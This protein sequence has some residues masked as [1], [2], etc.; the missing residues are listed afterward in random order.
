MKKIEDIIESGTLELYV[1]G[2]LS[3][4][5]AMEVED[6][7]EEYPEVKREV[8]KIEAAL[9]NLSY[10]DSFTIPNSVWEGVL[11]SIQGVRKLNVPK[12]S[13]NWSMMTG[14][15][16]AIVFLLGIFWM[17]KEN[18]TLENQVRVTSTQNAVLK[19]KVSTT[20]EALA[21]SQELLDIIR[22]KD[23]REINLPGNVAVSPESYAKVY[24][25]DKDKIAYIDARGLPTPPSGKVYQVWSLIMDPL[26]PRSVGL[27]DNYESTD[28]KVFK[29]E[30]IPD[31]EAFGI[32]LEPE[33]GSESP[34]LNQLYTLGM[35]SP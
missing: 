31:P 9:M 12:K 28:T 23:Y 21:S 24:Y 18:N 11:N 5:E 35:V 7:L 20:E 30:N 10:D 1:T 15:A 22:S 32:T 27:L 13:T 25:N 2:A 8:E 14:W 16:A 34:T 4:R 26:T 3:Q 19:G 33:G 17:L 6:I 29:L